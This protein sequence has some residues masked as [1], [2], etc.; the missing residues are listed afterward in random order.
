M[1]GAKKIRVLLSDDHRIVREGIRSSLAE[2]DFISI[3]GEASDGHAALQKIK[4]LSPDIVLMDLNMPGMGGLEATRVAR[5]KFPKTKVLALTMHDNKEYISEILR[6]GAQ[7]YV[8]KDTSPEQLVQAIQAVI[9]GDAFF[10]PSVSRFLLN[11]FTHRTPST[12]AP[13]SN[14][15]KREA[16]VLG[17]IAQGNTNKEIAAKLK[18]STRTVETYRAR[19]MK[20][21]KAR[22]AAE[23]ARYAFQHNLVQ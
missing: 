4:E 21:T 7:G 13:P 6:C 15:S 14:L 10:S 19:V 9:N 23:L 8:L 18:I 12:A 1:S 16:E 17:A 5:Q 2:Y 22:N 11:E 3:V 20:K